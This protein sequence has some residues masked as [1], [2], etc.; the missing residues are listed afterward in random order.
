MVI[1]ID[2]TK[3]GREKI[4]KKIG[5]S[6]DHVRLYIQPFIYATDGF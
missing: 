5:L 3:V 6:H 2:N 4:Y 1:K